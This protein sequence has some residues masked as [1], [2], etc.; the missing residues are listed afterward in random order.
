MINNAVFTSA[1]APNAKVPINCMIQSPKAAQ[2]LGKTRKTF[3]D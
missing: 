1:M 2:I 3:S